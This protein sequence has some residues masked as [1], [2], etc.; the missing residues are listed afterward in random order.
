M[1]P[2]DENGS[3]IVMLSKF[4][5]E[6]WHEDIEDRCL[7]KG[8]TEEKVKLAFLRQGLNTTYKNQLRRAMKLELEKSESDRKKYDKADPV[9][10]PYT[11]AVGY[12]RNNIVKRGLDTE[13]V[14][15]Q[16]E[17]L[18]MELGAIS[19][20]HFGFNLQQFHNRFHSKVE[21]IEAMGVTVEECLLSMH[22]Q[23]ACLPHKDLKHLTQ[24]EDKRKNKT[25][26]ELYND[27]VHALN[28]VTGTTRRSGGTRR[29]RD[30]PT[31][32]GMAMATTNRSGRGNCDHCGKPGHKEADCWT[33]YPDKVP[34]WAK[35]LR[36]SHNEDQ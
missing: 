7:R 5:F 32:N 31:S 25:Y 33:K 13:E 16:A 28:R 1:R 26:T 19:I 6:A 11:W 24:D 3:K 30:G 21:Q 27:Y 23:N 9:E 20:A 4:N 36:R 2:N 18:K 22:Y 8:K 15:V 34:D 14:M 29:Q 12:I 17:L 10:K 35:K